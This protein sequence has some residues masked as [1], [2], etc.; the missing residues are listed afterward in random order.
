MCEEEILEH[1]DAKVAERED[2]Q[3]KLDCVVAFR[4]YVKTKDV[5][6]GQEVLHKLREYNEDAEPDE[7][8]GVD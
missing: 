1:E 7:I 4:D 6:E 8:E 2:T 3:N 5:P